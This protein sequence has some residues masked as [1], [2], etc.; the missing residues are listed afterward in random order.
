[1][2]PDTNFHVYPSIAKRE[3]RLDLSNIYNK[4][5][6]YTFKSFFLAL[7]CFDFHSNN[8][9]QFSDTNTCG[10]SILH[11]KRISNPFP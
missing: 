4:S 2:K 9:Y 1:M 7:Q 3:K 10:P 6:Q 5:W 11:E 8:Y